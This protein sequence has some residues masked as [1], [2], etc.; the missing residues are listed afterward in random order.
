MDA[1]VAVTRA[2]RGRPRSGRG[3]YV[4]EEVRI[5]VGLRSTSSCSPRLNLF[6][7]VCK[8]NFWAFCLLLFDSRPPPTGEPPAHNSEWTELAYLDPD[9]ATLKL[10]LAARVATPFNAPRR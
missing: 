10:T 1:V 8:T 4:K 9:P 7:S 6:A 5:V 3:G 2:E